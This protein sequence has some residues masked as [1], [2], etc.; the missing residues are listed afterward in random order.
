MEVE[1]SPAMWG[2]SPHLLRTHCVTLCCPF[3][4]IQFLSLRTETFQSHGI[5]L[6]S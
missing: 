3:Q 4:R 5:C 2:I 1:R 6:L